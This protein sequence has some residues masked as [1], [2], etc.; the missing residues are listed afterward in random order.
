MKS[1]DWYTHTTWN[2]EIRSKFYRRWQRSRTIYNKAQYLRVQAYYLLEAKLYR[3]AIELLEHYFREFAD[4]DGMLALA[5][6]FYARAFAGIDKREEAITHFRL[7]IQ[8]QRVHPGIKT[9]AP[10]DFAIFI[11]RTKNNKLFLEGLQGLNDFEFS[12]KLLLPAQEYTL[13]GLRAILLNLLDR[14]EEAKSSAQIAL[15]AAE[16]R[17]SGLRFH[18]GFGVVVDRGSPFHKLLEKLAAA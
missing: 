15:A 14:K 13:N 2:D 16:V 18:P 12:V 9:E 10:L 8:R 6:L 3:P 7:A 4:K 5:H 1:R 11:I 17:N